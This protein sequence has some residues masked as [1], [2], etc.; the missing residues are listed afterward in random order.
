MKTN[1]KHK[2][3]FTLIEVLVVMAI[4]A[5]VTATV[6]SSYA[7][8]G[9]KTL[10]KNLA[11]NIALTIREAQVS[12]LTGRNLN[13]NQGSYYTSHGVFFSAATSF[14]SFID[15]NNNNRM[16]NG[17]DVEFFTISQGHRITR[18]CILDELNNCNA[19]SE[20]NISFKRPEPDAYIYTNNSGPHARAAIE[21]K[22]PSGYTLYVFIESSGQISVQ[23]SLN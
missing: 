3:A 21:V 15:S 4:F 18:L 23:S 20:L 17:E 2:S 19:V 8:F 6:M 16:D 10:L 7:K 12:G 11:Y 22:S 13:L 9:N 14:K 5:T 1:Y